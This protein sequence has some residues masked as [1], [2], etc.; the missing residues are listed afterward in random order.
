MKM[1]NIQIWARFVSLAIALGLL[2]FVPAGT[3]GYWQA[4]VYLIVFF[5]PSVA[6]TIYFMKHD[7]MLVARRMRAGPRAE[8]EKTQKIIM[9]FSIISFLGIFIV[10]ALDYRFRWSPVPIATVIV[11]D[12]VVAM[13][14]FITVLVV[15]QNKFASAT[16]EVSEDQKV[17]SS[18]LYSIV[19]HPMY[20]GGLLIFL[21]TPLALDSLWGL[22]VSVISIIWL[23]WRLV[24]EE[25]FLAEKLPGYNEYRQKVQYRLVPCF[26]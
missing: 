20:F 9:L 14:F 16:V 19:R 24:D 5:A 7:P 10:S 23:I 12:I 13:G 8:K 4:W 25:N 6:S 22:A 26:W 1:L 3:I 15:K 11:G 2:L 21:G 18:G 17:I